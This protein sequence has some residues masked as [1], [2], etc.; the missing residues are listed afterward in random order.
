MLT[1]DLPQSGPPKL[2]PSTVIV[3]EKR[4]KNVEL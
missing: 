3:V 2:N 4:D 1:D